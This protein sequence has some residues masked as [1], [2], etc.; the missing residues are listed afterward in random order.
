MPICAD[1]GEFIRAILKQDYVADGRHDRWL[2]WVNNIKKKYPVVPEN[3]KNKDEL[4]PYVFIETMFDKLN[5]DDIVACGNGSACVMTFQACKIKQGMRVFAN[6][7][8]ASMGYG[9]PAS[10]GAAMAAKEKRVIC[11]DGDGSFMMNM[12]ELQTVAH[13]NFNIKIFL[14]NN[15]FHID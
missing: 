9:F 3:Y 1:A 11:L 10:I 6:S 13:N 8:C 7:G 5:K 2:E 4:N 12:Q 15:I 14:I